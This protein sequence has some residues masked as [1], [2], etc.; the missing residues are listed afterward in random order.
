MLGMS[1][2]GTLT[3]PRDGPAEGRAVRARAAN[4]A[5]RSFDENVQRQHR[6]DDEVGNVNDL[7]EPQ[8]DRD[9]ADGVGLRAAEPTTLQILEHR[10]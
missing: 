1:L 4:T 2:V 7:A 9:A 3:T 8:I 10:D 5:A 6:A